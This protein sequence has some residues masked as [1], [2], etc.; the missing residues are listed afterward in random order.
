MDKD[1]REVIIMT[2]YKVGQIIIYEGRRC[3][4]DEL[5]DHSARLINLSPH[6]NSDWKTLEVLLINI[7]EDM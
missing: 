4:I 1:N 6:S 2:T 3:K 7:K 5:N